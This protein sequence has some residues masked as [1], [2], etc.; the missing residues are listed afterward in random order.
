MGRSSSIGVGGNSL[1]SLLW[2]KYAAN[3]PVVLSV[4]ARSRFSVFRIS[5]GNDVIEDTFI[6]K[7]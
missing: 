5:A 7:I 6:V 1:C 2:L 3:D 4:M